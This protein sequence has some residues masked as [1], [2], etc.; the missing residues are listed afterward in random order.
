MQ[1][2]TVNC[3]RLVYGFTAMLAEWEERNRVPIKRI[4]KVHT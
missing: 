3:S 2:I 4:E 1:S